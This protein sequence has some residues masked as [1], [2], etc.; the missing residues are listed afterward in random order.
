MT[1]APGDVLWSR[2]LHQSSRAMAVSEG[3]V[4]VAERNSRL[5]GL[6]PLSGEPRWDE[7][8]EDCWGTAVVAGDRGLYLSQAG[9]LHCF[10]LATG[11]RLWATPGLSWCYHVTVSADVVFVGGWRGYRPLMRLSLV[12]GDR[13]PLDETPLV[14]LGPLAWPLPLRLGRPGQNQA[15]LVAGTE[16]SVLL[17]MASSGTVLA[18]WSLPQPIRIPDGDAA[19]DAGPGG[20][21]A[22][23]SGPRTVMVLDPVHGAQVL[24]QHTRDVRAVPPLLADRTLWLFDSAGIAVVDLD[25]GLV[26]A[27]RTHSYGALTAATRAGGRAWFA[28]ADGSLMVVDRSGSHTMVPR[29]LPRIDRMAAGEGGL[30]HAIAKG[31]LVAF[32]Q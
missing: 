2:C 4:V 19:Y 7:R 25:R 23:L 32:R 5:V 26:A 14:D 8:V 6:D 15:V 27:V 24:W 1:G 16:R 3:S 20:R 13:L 21:I 11:Q 17:M 29:L 18:E 28:F 10:D 12:N 31:H 9:V 30:I 22:F